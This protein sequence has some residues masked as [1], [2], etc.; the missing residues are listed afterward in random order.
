MCCHG[1]LPLLCGVS[2]LPLT[3]HDKIYVH[4]KWR[5]ATH[6]P[7]DR[8]IRLWGRNLESDQ[9]NCPRIEATVSCLWSYCISATLCFNSALSW[10][11]FFVLNETTTGCLPAGVYC[12]GRGELNWNKQALVN[13]DWRSV[14]PQQEVLCSSNHIISHFR[15]STVAFE[16]KQRWFNLNSWSNVLAWLTH[17]FKQSSQTVSKSCQNVYVFQLNSYEYYFILN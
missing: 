4:N 8:I 7:L 2:I 1:S 10:F 11:L 9:H 6:C 15:F 13:I 16:I 17:T 5:G 3:H 12:H 14:R